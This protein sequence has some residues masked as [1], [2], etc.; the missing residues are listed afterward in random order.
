MLVGW[1][2]FPGQEVTPSREQLLELP[3]VPLE[4]CTK[5]YS[6]VIPVTQNQMCVGGE[7]GR[8]ACSG[9]GGAP[10]ILL[11]HYTKSRYYQVGI[12]S[13]GSDKCGTAGVPSVYSSVHR[14]AEWIHNNMV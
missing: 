5:V 11:D 13:F 7:E 4:K 2:K 12:A 9:F 10:L 3:I 8:D 14:Y 6:R 1:G